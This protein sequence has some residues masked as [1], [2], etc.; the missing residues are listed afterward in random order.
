M[1]GSEGALLYSGMRDRCGAD[2]REWSFYKCASPDCGLI[3]LEPRPKP[4]EIAGLYPEC[5]YTHEVTRETVWRQLIQRI[6]HGRVG[7]LLGF[8]AYLHDIAPGRLL[9]VGCGSG[10][11]LNEMRELGW[12]VEGLDPDENAV[13]VSRERYGLKV[14]Q[15]TLEDL[16]LDSQSFEAITVN[17]VLEHILDPFSLVR[18]CHRILKPGGLLLVSC[19]NP[20]GLGHRIFRERWQHFDTPRHVYLFSAENLRRIAFSCGFGEVKVRT[21]I[22]GAREAFLH[23][24]V[25]E[26]C[27]WKGRGN[28]RTRVGNLAAVCLTLIEYICLLANDN[29]GEELVL[30]CKKG[31]HG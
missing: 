12:S 28:L 25:G 27:R 7:K 4:D 13:K 30:I 24:L 31:E 14:R 2:G 17:H 6:K 26:E 5:Y 21:S 23:G 20:Q 3:W 16:R 10:Y 15:G 1:C 29:L 19:P 11:Y 18:E 8:Y 9:D 22:R